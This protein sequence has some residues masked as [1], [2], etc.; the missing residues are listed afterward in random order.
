MGKKSTKK[1]HNAK[2]NNGKEF[3]TQIGE[4]KYNLP[5]TQ[6]ILIKSMLEH[7]FSVRAIATQQNVAADTVAK[8]KKDKGISVG[9]IDS[10]IAILKRQMMQKQSYM[11]LMTLDKAQKVLESI[12]EDNIP[13]DKKAMTYGILIDKA[14][15]MLNQS[16][17]NIST[18]ETLLLAVRKDIDNEIA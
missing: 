18:I 5:D 14:R 11:A 3:P 17:Q 4:K 9:H 12:D 8:I 1:V 10:A 15:L 16:T 2:Y 13:D 6:I 7:G